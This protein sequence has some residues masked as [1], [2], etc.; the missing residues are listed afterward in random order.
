[1][2]D[3]ELFD[4]FYGS[5]EGGADAD[6]GMSDLEMRLHNLEV[7]RERTFKQGYREGILDDSMAE[8]E[9][10]GGAGSP[11]EDLDGQAEVDRKLQDRFRKDFAEDAIKAFRNSFRIA[12]AQALL[13]EQLVPGKGVVRKITKRQND[14]KRGA[15]VKTSGGTTVVASVASAASMSKSK[16]SIISREIGE[17]GKMA[18][19]GRA[20]EATLPPGTTS[21][22]A[23]A[24]TESE[25]TEDEGGA[26]TQSAKRERVVRKLGAEEA[27]RS[28][29]EQAKKGNVPLEAWT[30]LLRQLGYKEG[31]DPSLYRCR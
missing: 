12:F 5:Q 30:K 9:V 26:P 8:S 13:N 24:S 23:E 14:N 16:T 4:D 17:I 15:D 27:A 19:R 10:Y 21:N 29:V 25:H 1:M 31:E 2:A 18:G 20:V 6:D 11:D 3:D 7:M 28:V 22:K